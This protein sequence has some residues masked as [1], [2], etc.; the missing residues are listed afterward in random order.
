MIS[1]KEAK[2]M[3]FEQVESMPKKNIK[4]NI[5]SVFGKIL[6]EDLAAKCDS[7]PFHQSAMDGYALTVEN[8]HSLNNITLLP[9]IEVTAGDTKNLKLNLN[10]AVRIFTGARVPANCN[11]VIP[12][13][14]VQISADNKLELSSTTFSVNDNIRPKGSQFTKGEVVLEKGCTMNAAKIAIAIT[15]GYSQLKVL[16]APKIHIIVTGNELALPGS[17]LKSGQIYESNSLMV[18]ALL[19]EHTIE[20]TGITYAKDS[21]KQL[22]NHFKKAFQKADIVLVSGG[23]SVGKYDLVQEALTNLKTQKIFYKIKQKPGKPLY[24]GRKKNQFVFGLPGNP[25]ATLTCLYEYVLPFIKSLSGL[26][27]V[28]S[29]PKKAKLNNDYNKKAG[30]THFL[31]AFVDDSGITILPDQ[32]SYKL[33]SFAQANCLAIIPE[34]C[35][36]MKTGDLV[37]YHAI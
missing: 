21:L 37:E 19:A 28:N 20:V 11:L 23:I 34:D 29:L 4:L 15:A 7:P 3:L 24:F 36:E 27:T 2:A 32:E 26:T 30:L 17:T 1:I 6:A 13:E 8:I 35:T 33:T 5:T 16:T 9:G 12:Q 25:A 14:Y 18:A 22:E 10:T 31:K